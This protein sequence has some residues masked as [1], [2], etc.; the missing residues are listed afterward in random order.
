MNPTPGQ[1]TI[2]IVTDSNEL[3][4]ARKQDEQFARNLAWWEA[5]A[6][7]IGARHRGKCI[8]IAGEQLFVADAPGEAISQAR[9]AHPDDAGLFVHYIPTDKS[10][11]IYAC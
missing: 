4:K 7:E 6:A 5:H 8:A 10:P 9:T 1:Y 2:E 11:R 3:A